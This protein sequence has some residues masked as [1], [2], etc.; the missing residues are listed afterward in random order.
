MILRVRRKVSN[1][2]GESNVGV[3]GHVHSFTIESLLDDIKDLNLKAV[4]ID[5]EL[6]LIKIIE[7]SML[8]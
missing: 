7:V 1:E 8:N 2:A 4:K 5:D 3:R 6:G